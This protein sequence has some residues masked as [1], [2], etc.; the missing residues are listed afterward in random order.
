MR[1][2]AMLRPGLC[3]FR[4]I[5]LYSCAV[6]RRDK[7]R[8]LAVAHGFVSLSLA[9]GGYVFKDWLRPGSGHAPRLR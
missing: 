2:A 7:A 3:V 9:A 6:Q 5:M 4:L 8:G 1:D